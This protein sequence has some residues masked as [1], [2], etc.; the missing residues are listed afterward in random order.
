ML[1]HFCHGKATIRFLFIVVDLDV[2]VNIKVFSIALEIKK[3]KKKIGSIFNVVITTKY[4]NLLLG[5][6]TMKYYGCV[7]VVVLSLSGILIAS[8][9]R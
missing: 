6:K 2:A 5:I 1:Q 8:F 4:F 7:S 9:L 3:K